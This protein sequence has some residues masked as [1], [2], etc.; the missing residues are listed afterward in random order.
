MALESLRFPVGYIT[1][2]VLVTGVRPRP[3]LVRRRYV[4]SGVATANMMCF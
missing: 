4:G 1:C 2:C 3:M